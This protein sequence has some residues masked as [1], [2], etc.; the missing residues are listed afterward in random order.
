MATQLANHS[1]EAEL[2]FST[3]TAEKDAVIPFGSLL[4]SAGSG[5]SILPE[6]VSG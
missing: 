3:V 6:V 1:F 5:F 4:F 2:L